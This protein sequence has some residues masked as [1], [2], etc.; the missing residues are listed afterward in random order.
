M[1]HLTKL[2][3]T[4]FTTYFY[5]IDL[6]LLIQI[7]VRELDILVVTFLHFIALLATLEFCLFSTIF[8]N[9]QQ[10]HLNIITYHKVQ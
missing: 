7:F 9:Y 10:K 6:V 4:L 8:F 2:T 1:K 3:A 5:F